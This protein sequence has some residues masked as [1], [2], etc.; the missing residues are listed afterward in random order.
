MQF[1]G[2]HFHQ[3]WHQSVCSCSSSIVFLHSFSIKFIDCYPWANCCDISVQLVA[4]FFIQNKTIIVG[5]IRLYQALVM[6]VLLYAAE[7]CRG[8]LL[9]CDEKN[10][11]GIPHEVSSAKFC[12]YT[13]LSMSLTRKYPLTPAYHLLWTSSEDVACQQY[14]VTYITFIEYARQQQYTYTIIKCSIKIQGYKEFRAG[15]RSLSGL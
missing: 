12:T 4:Y 11:G 1:V 6:S 2:V 9:S 13:G 14:S 8:T 3:N 10:V 5:N 7:T 15:A